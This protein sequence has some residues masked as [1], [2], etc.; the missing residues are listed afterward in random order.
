MIIFEDD[1]PSKSKLSNNL[2]ILSD[3][4]V[5]RK[6]FD[7]EKSEC[8]ALIMCGHAQTMELLKEYSESLI[9]V[10]L[11]G[12]DVLQE[13][14]DRI[15]SAK[16]IIQNVIIE[17]TNCPQI[18]KMYC[19]I[20]NYEISDSTF[21]T[22]AC[23]VHMVELIC[24]SILKLS[25]DMKSASQGYIDMIIEYIKSSEN[26]FNPGKIT[27]DF[28]NT[29]SCMIEQGKIS[30][31]NTKKD[32]LPVAYLKDELLLFNVK[33]FAEIEQKI[34]F[35]LIDRTPKSNGIRLRSILHEEGYLVTN[36]GD[37]MLY[38]TSI[39]GDS[40]NRMNYVAIKKSLLTAEAQ[41]IVPVVKKKAISTS[42][43]QPPDNNDSMERI[44][45]GTTLDTGQ[46]VYWSIGNSRLSNKHLYIQADSG[47]GKTTLLF[48]LA[49]RLYKAGKNVI[50]LDFAETESYSK[51]K[52]SYM[53]DNLIKNTGHSVFENGISENDIRRCDFQSYISELSN[54][55]INIIDCT[56][57]EAV[58]ILKNIFNNLNNNN[59]SRENDVYVILDEINSLNFDER[60]SENNDQTVADVIFRQG[61]SIGLNLVSATQFLSKK[62]SK[63]KAQ[64]FNQSATKIA[65]HMNSSSSTGVAKSISV[66]GYSYYKEV[67][68]KMTV[69]QALV[70]SGVECADNSITNDVPLQIKI[71][72]LDK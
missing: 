28:R 40:T 53:N 44:L 2:K 4:F 14:I 12:I 58:N 56:P 70:Y 13:S 48:L 17:I 66:S 6:S 41:K 20:D 61:R 68:E 46:P 55:C 67:L 42:G 31:D 24:D 38:K 23:A 54:S 9:W 69:G 57:I 29:L 60:F 3:C 5:K 36:N 39:S 47:S 30:F 63:N 15:I 26:F 37:K 50:I 35:G 25:L 1:V 72:P 10:D 21:K 8:N 52:I 64:L 27:E 18:V 71:L 34:P 19:N 65:L 49:Q 45:L 62:G 16:K 33:D 11:S 59:H 22:L 51:H 32:N 7:G 43:Y